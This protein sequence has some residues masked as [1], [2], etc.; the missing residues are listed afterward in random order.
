MVGTLGCYL[1]FSGAESALQR[2]PPHPGL[3]AP[4]CALP[5]LCVGVLKAG[6]KGA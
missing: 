1:S 2:A 5:S 6:C 4:V 3:A